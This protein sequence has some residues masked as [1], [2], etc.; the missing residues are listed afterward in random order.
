M[1][2][3]KGEKQRERERRSTDPPSQEQ[4]NDDSTFPPY[5]AVANNGYWQY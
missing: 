1:K 5:S 3:I 2:E 4:D